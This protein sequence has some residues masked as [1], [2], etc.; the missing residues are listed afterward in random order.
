[1]LVAM[2]TRENFYHPP[3]SRQ[4]LGLNKKLCAR[5]GEEEV[6]VELYKKQ[7]ARTGPEMFFF[8]FVNDTQRAM[9]RNASNK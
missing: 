8:P 4:Q 1:M 3:S 2:V 5:K 7:H 9:Q 6:V